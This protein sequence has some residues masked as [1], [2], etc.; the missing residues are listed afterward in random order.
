MH[1]LKERRG[2]RRGEERGEE[3]CKARQEAECFMSFQIRGDVW[4]DT[5]GGG[6]Q[7]YPG[8]NAKRTIGPGSPVGPLSP[9]DPGWPCRGEKTSSFN[10]A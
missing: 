2:E 1:D 9:T 3:S 5:V 4:M 6:S 7:C 8:P 10:R